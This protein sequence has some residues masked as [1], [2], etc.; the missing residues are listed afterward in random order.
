MCDHVPIAKLPIY[1]ITSENLGGRILVKIFEGKYNAFPPECFIT[2][3]E[4]RD[5]QIDKILEDE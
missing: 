1:G 5:K 3:A 2:L 4:W